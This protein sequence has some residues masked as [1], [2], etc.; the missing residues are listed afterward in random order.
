MHAFIA[1]VPVAIFRGLESSLLHRD[2]FSILV[3]SKPLLRRMVF[4][5]GE[6]LSATVFDKERPI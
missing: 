5:V 1:I 4:N 2:D 6:A 3:V